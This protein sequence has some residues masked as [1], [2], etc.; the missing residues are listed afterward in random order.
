MSRRFFSVAALVVALVPGAASVAHAQERAT[1]DLSAAVSNAIT[2]SVIAASDIPASAFRP[3]RIQKRSSLMTALYA[4]TFTMQ[5]LDVHSTLKA[6]GAGAREANPLMANVTKNKL[7]FVALKAGIA[8][9]TVLAAHSM[10]RTNK[11]GAVMT[12]VAI[13]SAYAMIVD[14]NYRVARNLR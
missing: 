1:L 8:T 2:P 9:S 5:A 14:H 4:S 3:A 13:N 6:F 10:S 7:A 12:L 11:I